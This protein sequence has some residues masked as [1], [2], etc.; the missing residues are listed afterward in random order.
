MRGL[1][2][3]IGLAVVLGGFSR[4]STSSPGS[5]R[6]RRRVRSW[7]RC[8][9]PSTPTRSGSCG[10]GAQRRRRALKKEKDGWRLAEP[11][12]AAASDTEASGITSALASLEIVGVIDEK[13]ASLNDYGL[14]TPRIEVA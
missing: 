7:T 12:A 2:T 4:T 8:S 3:T 6:N 10:V 1:R 5:S 9:P 14:T 13:P 11:V